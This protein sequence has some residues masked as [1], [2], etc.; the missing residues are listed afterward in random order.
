MSSVP[1]KDWEHH[2]W[3]A[4][5]FQVH[6]QP[7]LL[8]ETSGLSSWKASSKLHPK[9]HCQPSAVHGESS[10]T[11]AG[12]TSSVPDSLCFLFFFPLLLYDLKGLFKCFLVI[13]LPESWRQVFLL[14]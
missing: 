5:L 2:L 1:K 4:C 10:F 11:L 9:D 8:K 6:F 13:Y 7:A 14:L 12:Q 3:A